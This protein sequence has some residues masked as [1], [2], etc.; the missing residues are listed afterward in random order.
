MKKHKFAVGTAVIVPGSCGSRA[1]AGTVLGYDPW[2]LVGHGKSFNGHAGEG[3]G[4]DVPKKYVGHCWW[5][6]ESELKRKAVKK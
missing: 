1:R 3:S 5:V 4:I 6:E 2:A